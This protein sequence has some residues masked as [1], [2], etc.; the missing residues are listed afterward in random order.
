MVPFGEVSAG[1]QQ[2]GCRG[3]AVGNTPPDLKMNRVVVIVATTL[4]SMSSKN[5]LESRYRDP[6]TKPCEGSQPTTLPN[7]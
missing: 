7:H 4:R 1:V 5:R 6:P 3:K 2:L